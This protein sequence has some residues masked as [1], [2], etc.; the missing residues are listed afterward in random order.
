MNNVDFKA[1][2][3]RIKVSLI[4]KFP[5]YRAVN[6]L[7]LDYDTKQVMIYMKYTAWT[8]SKIL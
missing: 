8:Q 1:V 6:Y 3:A 4:S 2:R 5:S 7:V